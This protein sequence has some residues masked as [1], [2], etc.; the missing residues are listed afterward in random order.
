MRTDDV[1]GSR[2]SI[3]GPARIGPWL[4]KHLKPY[5][6]SLLI[7]LVGTFAW[8]AL[9][10]AIPRLSGA[11]FDAILRA[12]PDVNYFTHLVAVLLLVVLVRGA[13]GIATTYTLEYIGNGVERDVRAALYRGLLDKRQ[14]FF[15]RWRVGELLARA[16]GD[17][18]QIN[19]LFQ[20]GLEFLLIAA[21]GTV[22]PLIVIGSLDPQLLLAPIIFLAAFALAVRRHNRRL[23]PVSDRLQQR[24]GALSARLS[25]SLAGIDLI[26]AAGQR[27]REGRAFAREACDYRD[28]FIRRGQAQ[29]RYLP[30]LLVNVALAGGL[31]HGL[32]LVSSG[33][34]TIGELVA[35]LGLIGLLQQPVEAL[36]VSVP[37][38]RLGLSSARRI[39]EVLDESHA[40]QERS[41]GHRAEL[42]GEIV[43][44]DVRFAYDDTPVLDGVSFA[45]GRGET[46]ALVGA[47]G[48]GKSTIVKLLNR[49]YD[50][51]GGRVVVDGIDLHAWDAGALC[52]Q[53]AIIEQDVTLFARSIAEN[54]ALGSGPNIDRA[55]IERAAREAQAHEFIARLPDGYD[56][57]I[58]ERGTTLSGGQRQRL[59]V[60]RALLTEPKIL[61]L[62]D[63]TSAVDSQTDELLRRALRRLRAG[64]TTLLITNRLAEIRHADRIVILDRGR[65]VDQGRHEDLIARCAIYRRIFTAYR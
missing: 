28:A 60:A 41:G 17:A 27:A 7:Y 8:Q 23:G 61:V 15:D 38:I 9:T 63:A 34:L 48:A 20:P 39:V 45:V 25:E 55:R 2:P 13:I 22:L 56:T 1:F 50:P 37:L 65:V 5:R 47:T 12:A 11:G 29:A 32:L 24:A 4:Q 33:R 46:I 14:A 57:L 40:R 35:Y 31:L 6:G 19:Q 30:P 42:S 18:G 59:A 51:V 43:F 21:Y 26:A 53:I 64:R 10:A 49:T 16:T 3:V 58:G 44:E 36:G 62:D 54:I 52:S